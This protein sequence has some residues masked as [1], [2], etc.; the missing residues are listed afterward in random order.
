MGKSVCIILRNPPYGTV[1]AAEAVRHAL[2]GVVE[3]MDVN[4]ILINAGVQAARKDQNAEGTVYE[5]IG[6]GVGDCIDMG[7]NVFVEK[8]SL[9]SEK[10]NTSDLIDGVQVAGLSEIA[11]IINEA[12][13]T[14][15]F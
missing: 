15:I 1:D 2:G 3:E 11:G 13:K 7:I 5:S 4:F 8:E 12:H 14:M 9:G 10:I 6:S